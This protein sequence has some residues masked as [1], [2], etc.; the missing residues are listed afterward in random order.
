MNDF[1]TLGRSGLVVSPMALGAMTFGPQRWGTDDQGSKAVFDAFIDA[2]GNFLDTAETYSGGQSET[3]VGRFIAERKLRDKV[4]LATKFGWAGP[5]GP[6][7]GGNGA[8]NIRR[9]VE[10]S[11][12]RLGSDWIDL[13]WLHVWDTVTPVEEVLSTLGDLVT[14]GKIRYFGLS[15]APAWYAAEMATLARAHGRP[16]PIALQL[17]YP[18]TERTIEREHVP[19]ACSFGLG[20][21]PWSPL[22][23]GFLAG[24]YRREDTKSQGGRLSGANPFGDSKF[25]ER[26]WR[27]LD[28]L[29][30]VAQAV[31]T[32][33]GAGGPG[34]GRGAAGRRLRSDRR[35]PAGAGPGEPRRA[36]PGA[37]ERPP[38]RAGHGQRARAGLPVR[39]LRAGHQPHGVR[40][41]GAALDLLT[42]A[43][44]EAPGGLQ[45]GLEPSM[46][47]S[48]NFTTMS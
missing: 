15:N 38:G 34:L 10:G 12:Q 22:D 3:L 13:Y 14:C 42:D 17:A 9:A 24:K 26:N 11:L 48:K 44:A 20:V 31:G 40:N 46:A 37:C 4:V 30:S 23:G 43:P 8:K 1:R 2:G 5:D 32:A 39:D 6:N 21:V 35:E 18:L 45:R 28:V 19:A 41:A 33:D 7:T 29:R 47:S 36:R 27:I 16:G 25:T